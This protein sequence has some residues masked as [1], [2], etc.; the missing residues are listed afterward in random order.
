MTILGT[1]QSTLTRDQVGQRREMV[2]TIRAKEQGR[3]FTGIG[4]PYGEEIELWGMRERFEPGSVEL[5]SEGVPSLVLWQHNMD[6]P[7][8]RIVSGTDTDAG[9]EIDAN[10]S[11]TARGKEAATLLDDGVI[12]RLSIGFIPVEWRIEVNEGEDTETIVHTK[13]RALEFSLVSFP[14]YA[15]A[16][17]S[18]VRHQSEESRKE[19]TVDTL[20]MTRA[21]I[22]S[23]LQPYG[24]DIDDLKRS[25][26]SIG[27]QLG[28]AAPSEPYFRSMGDYLKKIAAG[29]E[30]AL[31]F[32]ARATTGDVGLES[33][34][35]LGTFIKLVQERRHL[36]ELFDT[37]TLPAKGMSVSYAELVEDT[38]KAG[39]Q[40][41][42]LDD[43]EGPG[44]VRFDT[45]DA[46]VRTFGGWT[47]LSRQVIERVDVP[48]LD[49]VLTAMGL[50]YAGA[51]NAALRAEI[52][53]VIDSQVTAGN[54]I[55]LP[56]TAN[57]FD[58]RDAIIDAKEMFDD[59]SFVIDGLLVSKADF[60]R[61]QRLTYSE[62]PALKVNDKDEFSGTLNLPSADGDLASMPVH[63]IFGGYNGPMAFYDHTAVKSLE[64]PNA[65]TQLQDDNI[66]NLSRQF[67]LY[68]YMA[69]LKPFPSAIVPLTTAGTGGVE[70]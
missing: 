21:D 32:H 15:S 43:L 28:D 46:K 10:L 14:A 25:L 26:A 60:K 63:T 12:T 20:T 22:E 62:V 70:G 2:A 37:G 59:R 31:D 24:D 40:A 48:Y 65:P 53:S 19:P 41:N 16:A 13:V 34:T 35:K 11:Q 64:S 57:V 29:D 55:S 4:V 30:R 18:S 6:E 44:H 45:K 17:V 66:I 49:T 67:S 33:E 23:A 5:D 36:I 56:G 50:K 68:G 52:R 54:T 51:T 42:E 8:G 9:F 38:T 7:I 39:E 69:F 3:G 47:E 1:P 27:A 58:Y 61:L